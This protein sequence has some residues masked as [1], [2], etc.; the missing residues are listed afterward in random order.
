M[1]ISKKIFVA[2]V[3]SLAG[4]GSLFIPL[5]SQAGWGYQ[6]NF[7]DREGDYGRH[8][9]HRHWDGG[10]VNGE[11]CRHVEFRRVC[12]IDYDGYRQCF[13]VRRVVW[14]CGY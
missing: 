13:M 14:D 3:A 9:H 7:S 5:V 12:R 8:W 4:L 10:W 2:V 6:I 1:N 11:G